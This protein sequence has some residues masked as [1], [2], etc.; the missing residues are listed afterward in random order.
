VKHLDALESVGGA[1]LL[2]FGDNRITGALGTG[3]TGTISQQ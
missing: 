2:T 3:F 1:A